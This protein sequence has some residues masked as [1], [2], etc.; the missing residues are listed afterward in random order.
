MIKKGLW[1][2]I[3]LILSNSIWS[4]SKQIRFKSLT[5][6]DG[7]S[8]SSVYSIYQDSKGFMWFCTEDG[9]NRYDGKNF[10]IFRPNELNPNSISHKWI[11]QIYE[12]NSGIL[13][14]GSRGGITRFNPKTE[15]FTQYK[16]TL[17]DSRSLTN[18]TV[19]CMLEDNN[20]QLWIGTLSGLN[21]IDLDTKESSQLIAQKNEL[22]DLT[23]QINALLLDKNGKVWIGTNLGLHVYDNQA[24]LFN[25]INLVSAENSDLRIL[26]MIFENEKLWIGT[27]NGLICYS[28]ET[29]ITE[30]Y[31]IPASKVIPNPNQ[32]IKKLYL[33][34][35]NRLWVGNIN[36]LYEFSL[37]KKFFKAYVFAPDAS[38]SQSINPLKTILEDSQGNIWYGTF[39]T[40]LYKVDSSGFI[41]SYANNPSEQKSLSSNSVHSI[42]EDRAG[43]LWFGTF[44]AGISIYDPQSHKFELITNNPSDANS[45]SSNF[46]WSMLEAKDGSVWIGTNSNGISRFFPETGNFIHYTHNPS[47]PTSLSKETIRYIF[48]D[49]KD[50]IW[51]AT[52]GGGLNEFIPKTGTFK[53]YLSSTNDASTISN[54]H[55]RGIY[56]DDQ[57]LLWIGTRRGL[58]RFNPSTG[59]FKRFVKTINDTTCISHDYIYTGIHQDKE[60]NLWIGTI[61]GGLNKMNMHNETFK[62]YLHNPEDPESLS[63]NMIFWIYGDDQDILWLG[64]NRGLNRFD[65]KTEG[66]QQFGINEG[67]PSEVVYGILP[68]E[69]NNIWLSTNYGISKFNL[70]NLD[71][72]NYDIN[73]GLQSNEFNGGALHLG[74]SGNMY[75]G[76]VYGINIINPRQLKVNENKSKLVI[77]KF[78]ILGQEV[79][80]LEPF[81]EG[82]YK[83]DENTIIEEN[84]SFYLKKSISYI[85]K[86]VLDYS[87]NFFSLEFAAL[88]TPLP[89][90]VQYAYIMNGL[91]ETWNYSGNRNYVSYARLKPDNYV[92]EVK[93]QNPDG[94]WG[95][96]IIK[97]NIKINPPFWQTWWFISLVIFAILNLIILIIRFLL[98]SKT[99]KLLQ[100]QNQE[101]ILI[102]QQLSE[103]E[104]HLKE[105]NDMKDKFFSIISHDLKNPFSSLLSMSESISENFQHADD[106]DKLTIFKRI[107]DS[108]KQINYLLNNLLTWSRSQREKIDI[109]PVAFNL[110]KLIEININLHRTPAEKKGIKL[111]SNYQEDIQ[112]Y[113][114]RE[115]INTVIRNLLSN[116]L[117]FSSENDSIELETKKDNNHI[118]VSVKDQG[119]GISEENL[120]KLFRI[121]VK[122]KSVG[123]SGEKGTGLGLVL[124][125]EF[126]EKNNGQIN[127]E[128][129]FGKG[130]VFRFTVPVEKE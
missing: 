17:K 116:A 60:G 33:D 109:E 24:Q 74:K 76:G 90:K 11:D 124:C 36:G 51:I 54:N 26:S 10:R 32:L 82:I 72:I 105:L 12:D 16:N 41:S 101:I 22:A 27:N 67:L 49:S 2:I 65:P 29:K 6:D 68:D 53:H 7:L 95:E 69:N 58:N 103:S 79:Q 114:D 123:T 75:F 9:L 55:I 100:A 96:S 104:N 130:S 66:F 23:S 94:L 102:N 89:D 119:V 8:L 92:F 127:V 43:V 77:T 64:T 126:V 98:K 121:D 46:V 28:P 80:V 73:D 25:K 107:H 128:S 42:Y 113:A 37:D 84:G 118:E 63:D 45:L 52:D 120:K 87:N 40:G 38:N 15:V 111:I 3:F 13:W 4:Q 30:H 93:A 35:Q 47:D 34:T 39:G 99:N 14:F 110:S 56:E 78:E 83:E 129:N 20:K 71:C 19:I 91:D 57:G 86:I 1:I 61:G 50:N 21:R 81:K 115:M 59:K 106:E 48:Q 117:K 125:K 88:N 18:D 122:Y 44:G 62:S 108:A 85:K 31:L 112:A 97:L 70:S 5:I